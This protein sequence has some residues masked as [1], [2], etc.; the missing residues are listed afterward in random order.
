MINVAFTVI[1]TPFS[2]FVR[3]RIDARLKNYASKHD[4][5]IQI[6]QDI[7]D[8]VRNSKAISMQKG[9]ASGLLRIGSKRR[10]T[11]AELEELKEERAE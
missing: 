9:S 5:N 4:L 10:R 8:V 1:G 6:D 11:R 7:L 2:D 3:N